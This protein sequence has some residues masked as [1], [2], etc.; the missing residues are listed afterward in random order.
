MDETGRELL[1]LLDGLPL[2]LAQA[3]S[4]LRETRLDTTSYVR[5]YKQQW[6]DL[7]RSD[8][9]SGSP[10]VDYEQRSVGTTWTISFKAIEARNKNAANLLRLWAF[11]DNKDL[12]HGLL[13]AAA[14]GREQWPG[15]LCEMACNEVR[16]LDAVR[17]LLRYS[18]I[19]A[20]ESVQGSYIMHP[21]VHRWTSHI[22]DAPE[23]REFL[24]LAV[25][26]VGFSVPSSTSKDYWMLQRRLLPHAERCSWWM[27][28]ICGAEWNFD[29]TITT[30]A[31]H[32]L[33]H[34]YADQGRLKEAEAMYQRALEG[35]EKALGPD[36]T[37]TLNTVNNLGR[38]YADQGRLK[39]AEAMYQRALEGYEKALGPDHTS[40]LTTVN[41]LGNLY[42]TQGKYI[43]YQN[44]MQLI[45]ITRLAIE[46]NQVFRA[47]KVNETIKKTNNNAL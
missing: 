12:W 16:F 19:E 3:A 15:W 34:L 36:H 47:G 17:L 27:G 30:D 13:Q 32:M 5:L 2:A 25:M 44:S 4:Y 42:K 8:G 7:M 41:N 28:E 45:F 33:G 23:R 37:S 38:L 46:N 14:D 20:Q 9:E 6:D 31:I 18:M 1:E 43:I 35:Y 24:Q 22:Q 11:V 21:V 10:L 39:E 40:T 29:D 26:V